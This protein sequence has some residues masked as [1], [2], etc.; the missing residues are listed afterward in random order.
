MFEETFKKI[1]RESLEEVLKENSD[2]I[3]SL[4]KKVDDLSEMVS[5]RLLKIS[6]VKEIFGDKDNRTVKSKLRK[7]GIEPIYI[8]NVPNYKLSDIMNYV[9]TKND[10]VLRRVSVK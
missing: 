1:I 8:N 4:A 6:E 9:E 10:N 7:E 5:V 2:K 3:E